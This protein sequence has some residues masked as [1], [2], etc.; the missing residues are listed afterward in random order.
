MEE[1]KMAEEEMIRV[2][3]RERIRRDYYCEGK[4]IR[5]IARVLHHGRDT[6]RD[7]IQSAE[8]G[9]CMLKAPRANSNTRSL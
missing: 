4:S 8:P 7:A 6:V 1:S 2:D 9:R 3:E 5:Q